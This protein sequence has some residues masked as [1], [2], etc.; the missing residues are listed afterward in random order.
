VRFDKSYDIYDRKVIDLLTYLAEIGGL[1]KALFSIG[2]I[3]VSFVAQKVFIS[4]VIKHTYQVRK[5]K[6]ESNG[7][8]FKEG[9]IS[10]VLRKN[11]M[12]KDSTHK[13]FFR[14]KDFISQKAFRQG[15]EVQG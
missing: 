10:E 6:V 15:S 4:N 2:T 14:M 11:N 9:V 13:W 3:I 5:A 12:H 7:S 8:D 1:H